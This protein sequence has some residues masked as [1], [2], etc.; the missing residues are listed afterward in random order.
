MFIPL[1]ITPLNNLSGVRLVF[2]FCSVG[3]EPH[4]IVDVK[5]EQWSRFTTRLVDDEVIECVVLR[6]KWGKTMPDSIAW[7]NV[8]GV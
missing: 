7:E 4:V 8:H 2:L 1:I 3:E 5:V 6:N